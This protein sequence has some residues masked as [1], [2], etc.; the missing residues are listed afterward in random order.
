MTKDKK[1]YII[2]G[3]GPIGLVTG[4]FLSQKKK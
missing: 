3:A 2:L 4:L 1:K